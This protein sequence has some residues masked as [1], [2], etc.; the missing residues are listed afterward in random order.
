MFLYFSTQSWVELD[1]HKAS[2]RAPLDQFSLFSLDEKVYVVSSLK[3]ILFIPP[4]FPQECPPLSYNSSH[5]LYLCVSW[6]VGTL[7]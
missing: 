2:M 7:Q 6:I 5:C 1:T 3:S 4:E